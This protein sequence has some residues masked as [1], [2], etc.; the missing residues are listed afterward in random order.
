MVQMDVR[1]PH[2]SYPANASKRNANVAAEEAV[3]SGSPSQVVNAGKFILCALATL[4]GIFA[5]AAI[6][7]AIWIWLVVKN[8]RYELTTQRLKLHSG[9]LNKTTDELELYRVTD[10]KFE[11]PFFLRLFSLGN[12]VLISSDDTTPTTIIRAI[13][14][15][16]PLRE[17]IRTFVE[18]RRDQKRVRVAEFE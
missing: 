6:P 12:V 11:Q 4:T 8:T 16:G 13:H 14:D 2:P 18:A 1:H 15:G 3:W 10:S 7:Y 17:K 5:I 9:V